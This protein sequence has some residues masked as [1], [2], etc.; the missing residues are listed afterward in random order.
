MNASRIAMLVALVG[1]IYVLSPWSF[2][3]GQIGDLFDG[4]FPW[5]FFGIVLFCATRKG[6]C[7]KASAG[8]MRK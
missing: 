3:L 4:S 5:I 1:L 7:G 8:C 6:V 2:S